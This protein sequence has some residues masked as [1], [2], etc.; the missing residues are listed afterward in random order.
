MN[1]EC[2]YVLNALG[3]ESFFR[4]REDG[5][6][7]PAPLE[8]ERLRAELRRKCGTDFLDISRMELFRHARKL[9]EYIRGRGEEA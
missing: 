2:R 8:D 7:E 9:Y 5:T 6:E 3:E 1:Y 4:Y